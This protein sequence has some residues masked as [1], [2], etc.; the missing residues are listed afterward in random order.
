[1]LR[2]PLPT[3]MPVGALVG[4]PPFPASDPVRWINGCTINVDTGFKTT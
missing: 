4:P 1:M 2:M 3:P